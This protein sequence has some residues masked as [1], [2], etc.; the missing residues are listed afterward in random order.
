LFT[1]P[2]ISRLAAVLLLITAILGAY[3]LLVEPIIVGYG[4]TNWD[5]EEA[6]DQLARFERAAAMR[7]ALV[8]Q[9]KDFE[10]QRK[11]QGYF[12]TGSTDAVAAAGLQDQVH[13]LVADKGGTL[14]SIQ[15]MPG[16]EE[17]GL[18][19]ITLRVQMTGTTETLFDV[20]YALESGSPILFIDNLDIQNR[21]SV[22]AGTDADGEAG[23]LTVAFDLSGY[24]PK[25]PQ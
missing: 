24:L 21:N 7:P 19:R 13:A 6:R 14:Q 17:Q 11:S 25:E 18:M 5:I 10:A 15:P 16:V 1:S 4:D 23:S 3:T 12:L 9:M 2:L 22:A 8:K 20:L